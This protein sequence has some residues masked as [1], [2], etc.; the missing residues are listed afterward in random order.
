MKY[1]VLVLQISP[2]KQMEAQASKVVFL[3]VAQLLSSEAEA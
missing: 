1:S 2:C 3:R